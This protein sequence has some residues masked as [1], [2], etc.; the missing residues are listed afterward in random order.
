MMKRKTKPTPK[1]T[2]TRIDDFA[3]WHDDNLGE[4]VEYA[5][6]EIDDHG[7]GVL[8]QGENVIGIWYRAAGFGTISMDFATLY[9]NQAGDYIL[10]SELDQNWPFDN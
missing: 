5:E 9:A 7:I 1:P 10:Y 4:N 8:Y 3:R 6:D 2:F